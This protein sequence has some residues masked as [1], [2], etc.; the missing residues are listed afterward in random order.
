MKKTREEKQAKISEADAR[1]IKAKENQ[2]KAKEV[3]K[4]QREIIMNPKK[5]VRVGVNN[6]PKIAVSGN[7]GGQNSY[8]HKE[9]V[10]DMKKQESNQS[11]VMIGE[12]SM[13][14]INIENSYPSLSNIEIKE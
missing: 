3:A 5:N 7:M 2:L 9:I 8:M 10:R 11:S 6:E 13:T 12:T 4:K 14:N 1:K